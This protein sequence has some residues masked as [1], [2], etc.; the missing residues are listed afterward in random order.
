TAGTAAQIQHFVDQMNFYK[1]IYTA[2]HAFGTD[3]N[4]IDLLARGAIYGQMI[5]VKAENP[6]T[7]LAAASTPA[8]TSLV[9]ISAQHDITHSVSCSRSCSCS[10]KEPR[11]AIR[12]APIGSP[13]AHAARIWSVLRFTSPAQ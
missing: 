5:G 13:A 4:L 12:N 11:A 2:S 10:F 1:S 7:A 9:G 6:T 8:D 3:A